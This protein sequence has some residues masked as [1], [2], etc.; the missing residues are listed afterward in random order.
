[1]KLKRMIKIDPFTQT[2]DEIDVNTSDLT[3]IRETM[4]C[5]LI[6]I[7]SLGSNVDLIVDDE[8]LLIDKQRY[9]KLGA[10]Y[11][12]ICLVSANDGEGNIIDCPKSIEDI[13][14]HLEWMPIDHVEEPY[15]EFIP[16]S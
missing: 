8:G 3:E 4:N 1:M 2:V 9:F 12:G 10:V 6:D 15:M 7:V 13:E 5:R 16:L 11:A 14:E